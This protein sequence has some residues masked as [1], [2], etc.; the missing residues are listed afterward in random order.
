MASSFKISG[1]ESIKVNF[2][3]SLCLNW[4]VIG[5]IRPQNSWFLF[6]PKG[7]S[8]ADLKDVKNRLWFESVATSK[9]NTA[10]LGD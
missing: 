3:F 2:Y 7:S 5:I 4:S 1:I 10:L 8:A 6:A 9:C